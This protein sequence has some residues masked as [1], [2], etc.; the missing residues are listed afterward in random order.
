MRMGVTISRV[1]S[2]KKSYIMSWSRMSVTAC[3]QSILSMSG[4]NEHE[5]GGRKSGMRMGVTISRVRSTKKSYIM[6]W[7]RMSVT[8]CRQSILSMSGVNELRFLYCEEM[9]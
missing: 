2:T 7:S 6:S 3:R 8:A 9:E 4:V 5:Q 1:R